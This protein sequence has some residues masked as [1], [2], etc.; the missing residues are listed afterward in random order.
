MFLV[1]APTPKKLEHPP[2]V[3]FIDIKALAE[4]TR[5]DHVFV[6]IH[7]FSRGVWGRQQEVYRLSVLFAGNVFRLG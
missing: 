4:P 7:F 1:V 3:V 2:T 5:G 6:H